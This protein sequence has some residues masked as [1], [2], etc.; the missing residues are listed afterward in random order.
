MNLQIARPQLP[1]ITSL[2][3]FAALHVVIFHLQALRIVHGPNWYYKAASIGYAGVSFFFVLSGFILVYTYAGREITLKQFWRARFARIYPA[4][5]FSLLINAP[6]FF[7]VALYLDVP[8]F[9]WA[10]AHL[11]LVTVLVPTLLQSWVPNAALSWNPVAWSLSVEAFF[12]L[13]FPF[14]MLVFLR[15]SRSQVFFIAAAAYL[16]TLAISVSYTL[17][18]PDHLAVID[19]DAVGAFWLNA[20]KFSPL[21]RVPEF[22]LGMVTGFLYLHSPRENSKSALPLVTVGIAAIVAAIYFCN[23][24]PYAILHT[25]LLGP[26]FA[27]IVYGFALRPS[28]GFVLENR[29][30][31]LLGEASYSL[32]LIHVMIMFTFFRTN[33][34]ELRYHGPWAV[35]V[36]LALSCGIA[37][38]IFLLIERPARRWLNPKRKLPPDPIPAERAAGITPVVAA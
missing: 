23:V 16:V 24:I 12:Y 8:F 27:A 32:Y 21:A 1:A 33:Q 30:L 7:Y 5:A 17:L 38:G 14:A 13:V 10:K 36:Y 4:Y 35:L 28:W 2:R 20:V 9:A 18:N 3:F 31:V 15:R 29:A 22:L 25:A 19:S 37:I 6:S 26:A 11:K 34:G